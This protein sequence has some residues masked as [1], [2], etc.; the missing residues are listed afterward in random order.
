MCLGMSV[1]MP[2]VYV[3][4][5]SVK[6][7]PKE[8]VISLRDVRPA[9]LV[10]P[11]GKFQMGGVPSYPYQ[12]DEDELPRHEVE[13]SQRY[14]LSETE[15]TQGQYQAVMGSNPSFF[16]GKE[17]SAKRP[18]EQVRW[19]DAVAYCNK[20]SMLE[21]LKK[22]YEVNGDAVKWP[23]GLGCEGYRLPTEAEWEYAARAD[24]ATIYSGSNEAEE[25]A[26]FEKNSEGSTHAVK[27][28]RANQWG[29]YDLSGNVTEWVWDEYETYPA[30]KQ[31]NPIGPLL[32]SPQRVNRG[33][34][35]SSIARR[36][37]AAGRSSHAPGIRY[38][39]VGFRLARSYPLT[40]LPANP[41]PT[42]E[43][44]GSSDPQAAQPAEEYPGGRDLR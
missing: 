27:G 7:L 9:M 40:L 20:L 19:L 18:V 41:L 13:I 28:K 12:H 36:V 5:K 22:C 35:W 34:S 37:R 8:Q 42:K 14:G 24:E 25:V 43:P 11:P 17:D 16:Q 2:M 44:P 21:G 4:W 26:W 31:K 23:E 10:L 3:Y 33:G 39:D 38:R 29:L 15:V 30:G 6:E 32:G 1:V